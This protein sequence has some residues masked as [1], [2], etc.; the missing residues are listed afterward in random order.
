MLGFG[1]QETRFVDAITALVR[2]ILRQ[3]ERQPQSR[4]EIEG[5]FAGQSRARLEARQHVI[6]FVQ[7][8]LH[9]AVEALLFQRDDALD[10]V[11]AL[12]DFAVMRAHVINDGI[13]DI[14]QEGLVETN[15]AAKSGQR[16][17]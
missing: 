16:G 6:Q 9:G 2:H 7:P 1:S 17:E 14:R 8:A 12:D 11:R 10:T 3:L 13:G 15:H 4:L 5:S